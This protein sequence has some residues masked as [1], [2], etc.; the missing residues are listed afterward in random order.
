MDIISNLDTISTTNKKEY[1]LTLIEETFKNWIE[2]DF[3]PFTNTN[4]FRLRDLEGMTSNSPNI[5]SLEM[6]LNFTV[7]KYFKNLKLTIS[8]WEF[9]DNID[10]NYLS[11]NVSLKCGLMDVPQKLTYNISLDPSRR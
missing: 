6:D 9:V 1:L 5:K 10:E 11:I 8:N 3:I 2:V 7:K 4:G